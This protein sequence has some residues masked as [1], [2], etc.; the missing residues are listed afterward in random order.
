M[1][2]Q[3]EINIKAIE[4][5]I[6]LV[7]KQ[8]AELLSLKNSYESEIKSMK[9]L[10]GELS[11]KFDN[12]KMEHDTLTARMD[13]LEVASNNNIDLLTNRIGL[14]EIDTGADH[15]FSRHKLGVRNEWA[16]ELGVADQIGIYDNY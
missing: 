4:L 3:T 11:F 8:Q 1:N 16:E 6:D 7:E 9:K 12:L 14:V 13:E 5:A 15:E 10:Y 2:N